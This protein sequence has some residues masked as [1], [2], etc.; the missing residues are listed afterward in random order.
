MK[1]A[2]QTTDAVVQRLQGFSGKARR[3]LT[4]DNGTENSGHEDITKAIGTRCYFA[5]PYA[6]WQRGANEQVNGMV[7][8]YFPK[9]T[10]FSKI[11]DEQVA[12]V[13]LR[14]NNRPRKCLGYKTPSEIASVALAP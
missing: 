5:D 2:G 1:T 3:T 9:G 11:T 4:L 12:W 7:R 10:D 8:R 13:E 6:S 14:I